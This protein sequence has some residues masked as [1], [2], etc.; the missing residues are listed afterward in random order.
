MKPLF[1]VVNYTGFKSI[2]IILH[3]TSHKQLIL[4]WQSWWKESAVSG[5]GGLLVVTEKL[6]LVNSP[7]NN[8]VIQPVKKV[9]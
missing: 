1:C 8:M 7:M 3:E 4:G 6:L 2:L 9:H 5:N